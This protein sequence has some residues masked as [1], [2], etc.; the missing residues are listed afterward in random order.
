MGGYIGP[1]MHLGWGDE[2]DILNL[3]EG[4][5]ELLGKG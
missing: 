2:K 5:G 1:Y 3:K 4:K